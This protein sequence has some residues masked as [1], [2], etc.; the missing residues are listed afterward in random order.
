M[1]FASAKVILSYKAC[2]NTYEIDNGLSLAER[3]CIVMSSTLIVVKVNASSGQIQHPLVEISC[4][5]VLLLH[6]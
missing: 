1:S 6:A 4:L 3:S 5:R 2:F